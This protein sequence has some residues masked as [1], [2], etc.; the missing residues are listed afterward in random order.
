VGRASSPV[1][2][3]RFG[4]ISLAVLRREVEDGDEVDVAGVRARVRP[5][6]FAA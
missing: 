5:L 6:P 2:S 4:P 3:P 1:V